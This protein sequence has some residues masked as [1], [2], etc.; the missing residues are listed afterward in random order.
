MHAKL[1]NAYL[2]LQQRMNAL[3]DQ[4]LDR[5]IDQKNAIP[6]LKQILEKKQVNS[7]VVFIGVVVPYFL[8]ILLFLSLVSA[9]FYHLLYIFQHPGLCFCPCSKYVFLKL[10]RFETNF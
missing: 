1:H 2:A 5:G 7:A 10:G 8:K 9:F 4:D 3:F 6:G